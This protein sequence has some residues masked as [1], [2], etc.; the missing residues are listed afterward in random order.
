LKKIYFHAVYPTKLNNRK[1]LKVFL[2]KIFKKEGRIVD[3]VDI[4]F[5]TDKYL[6][7]LNAK[8]LNHN[9]YTDTL[10][11]T[12]GSNPIIGEIYISVERIKENAIKLKIPA[13][14]ELIRVIIHSCLHLCGYKDKPQREAAR[15]IKVQEKY[16]TDWLVSRETQIGH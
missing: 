13:E 12:L 1:A 16:L 3:R 11:F 7:S 2:E 8:F 15:M 9:Y 10:T 4:I 14:I 5:C 6:L